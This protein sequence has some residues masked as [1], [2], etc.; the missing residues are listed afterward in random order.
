MESENKSDDGK[1]VYKGLDP[2]SRV[3]IFVKVLEDGQ[4]IDE[5]VTILVLIIIP[6]KVGADLVDAWAYEYYNKQDGAISLEVEVQGETIAEM[7]EIG[8]FTV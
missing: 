2:D 5:G 3:I 7:V 1:Q 4:S 6:C 8:E